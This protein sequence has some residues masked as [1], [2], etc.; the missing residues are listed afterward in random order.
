MLRNPE[1]RLYIGFTKNL[2]K[3]VK[4]H[5]DGEVRWT[6]QH[7]PWQMVY[8]E[9]FSTRPESMKRERILKS[10]KANQDLRQLIISS[11]IYAGELAVLRLKE[12][13]P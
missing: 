9:T 7:G 5:Q 12:F 2:E 10:G 4:R 6:S 11:I 8:S 1:G 13:E 3:R